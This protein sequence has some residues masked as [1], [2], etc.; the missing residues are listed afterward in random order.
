MEAFAGL[1]P[2]LYARKYSH[3]AHSS[4]PQCPSAPRGPDCPWALL[5]T[6]A[7]TSHPQALWQE[8]SRRRSQG[9][10][11]LP[12]CHFWQMSSEGLVAQCR[13]RSMCQPPTNPSASVPEATRLTGTA[14][15]DL[16]DQS[17][18]GRASTVRWEGSCTGDGD[19]GSGLET[20]IKQN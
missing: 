5:R 16:G 13:G 14:G 18:R 11:N 3:G 1:L 17:C 9:S 10:L 12:M 7:G 2:F 6:T 4:Q 20:P 15:C 8:L 19:T